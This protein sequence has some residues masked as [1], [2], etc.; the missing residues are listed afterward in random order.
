[1]IQILFGYRDFIK[2]GGKKYLNDNTRKTLHW[3]QE[4]EEIEHEGWPMKEDMD[5]VQQNP[6]RQVFMIFYIV[7]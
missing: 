1:M 7:I 4:N 6:E 3:I 5:C 2:G